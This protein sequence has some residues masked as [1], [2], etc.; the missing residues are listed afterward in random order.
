[1]ADKHNDGVPAMANQISADIPDIKENLEFHKDAL[2][3]LFETW[4]DSDNSTGKIDSGVGF[5][6]GTYNYLFPTNP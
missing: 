5:T 6:D 4:S 3:R 2:E 1:M